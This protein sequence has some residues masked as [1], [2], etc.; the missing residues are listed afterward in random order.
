[1][2]LGDRYGAVAQGVMHVHH[3]VPLASIGTTY[4]VHPVNDLRPVCPNCHVVIHRREPPFSI[5]EVQELIT[6]QATKTSIGAS[7]GS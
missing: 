1:L 2:K 5:E 3:I 7:L 4:Q 6:R